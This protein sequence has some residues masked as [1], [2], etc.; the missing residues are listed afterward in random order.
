M[1]FG[2]LRLARQS[3]VFVCLVVHGLGC[4]NASIS[5]EHRTPGTLV[6]VKDDNE[7]RTTTQS[8]SLSPTQAPTSRIVRRELGTER[9]AWI[10]APKKKGDT[11]T[12]PLIL[13]L[14]GYGD[15]ASGLMNAWQ[16]DRLV[17]NGQAY[18]IAPDGRRDRRGRQFWSATDACCNFEKADDSDSA[19]LQGLIRK[20]LKTF[21]IDRKRIV[22]VGHS[23]GGFMAYR[24]ACDASH[25]VSHI[26]V[27]AGSEWQQ[28]T[29]CRAEHPVSVLHLHGEYDRIV[30]ANG[31]ERDPGTS[32]PQCLTQLCRQESE[33]CRLTQGC[34]ADARCLEECLTTNPIAVCYRKCRRK[35]KIRE[36]P[37]TMPWLLCLAERGCVNFTQ[38]KLNAYPA[39]MEVSRR[40]AHRNGCVRNRS[41]AAFPFWSVPSSQEFNFTHF[42]QCNANTQVW[43]GLGHRMGH[44]LSLPRGFSQK[45]LTWAEENPRSLSANE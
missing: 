4:Q 31:R 25:L 9:P 14:H 36:E 32:Y 15:T 10:L 1:K 7:S 22:I 11:G 43:F 3:V 19:Y 37:T 38:F 23:N 35:G 45:V 17:E 30:L 6:S 2:C 41:F 28:S 29:R 18:L 42:S 40:W 8:N 39:A 12:L 33:R 16:F 21:P 24:L 5:K 26:V 27:S 44:A 20:A 13:L 34:R